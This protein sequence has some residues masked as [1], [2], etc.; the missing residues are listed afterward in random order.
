MDAVS[1]ASR[2]TSA[3]ALEQWAEQVDSDE[4]VVVDS[5]PAAL[6]M[7]AERRA[8]LEEEV[9]VAIVA[10]RAAKRSWS[11]IG[12][13]LGVSKLAA[14]RRDGWRSRAT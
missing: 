7:L 6:G 14:Q 12:A 2:A 9:A 8:A 4:L 1:G 13:M 11:Q 5:R 10:A 3:A